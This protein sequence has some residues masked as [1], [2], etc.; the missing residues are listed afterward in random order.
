M[1]RRIRNILI[2]LAAALSASCGH[3]EGAAAAGASAQSP[4]AAPNEIAAAQAPASASHADVAILDACLLVSQA[5]GESVLGAPAKQGQHAADDKHASHC[6][7]DAANQDASGYNSLSVE[8]HNDED[9]KEA[10]TTFAMQQTL[11]EKS[12]AGAVY[13]YE[14]LTGIGDNAFL[15]SNKVSEAI[16]AQMP[17]MIQDQQRIFVVKGAKDIEVGTAYMGKP[18]SADNLKA[19]AKK[20]ADQL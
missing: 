17:A 2:V 16:L 10:R 13:T 18:R 8:I 20:L 1:N 7:Y 15:V 12:N 3:Q 5:D 9:A 11:Y 19:L 4:A 6:Q 14:A